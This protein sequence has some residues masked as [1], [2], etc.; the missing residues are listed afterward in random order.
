MLRRDIS[1]VFIGS[2]AGA[3]LVSERAQAQACTPPCYPITAQE[4][5]AG[6]TPT[7]YSHPTADLRRFGGIGNG[8]TD[9]TLALQRAAAVSAAGGGNVI[10]DAGTYRIA[11]TASL[12]SNVTLEFRQGGMLSVD[13]G[14]ELYISGPLVAPTSAKIFP[15][16][17]KVIFGPDWSGV[18]TVY[19]EWWGAVPNGTVNCTD[20]IQN[21]VDSLS[22][23]GI[24]QFAAGQYRTKT[25]VAK[26]NTAFIGVGKDQTLLKSWEAGT[27]IRLEQFA[28]DPAA[29]SGFTIRDLSLDGDFIGT[30]GLSVIGY[31]HF[32]IQDCNI[33]KFK[34]RGVHLHGS[35][36]STIYRTRIF[37]CP[38]GFD[39]ESRMSQDLLVTLNAISLRDCY[40]TECS[41]Y[42]VRVR[43]GSLFAI[44]GG[45]IEGNGTPGDTGT[46]AVLFE[47]MDPQGLGVSAIIDGVWFEKNHGYSAIRI[48][49]PHT[50]YSMFVIRGVQ[51]IAGGRNYGI[52]VDGSG[53][54]PSISIS[55]SVF[56]NASVYD[57][58]VGT[59][60]VGT[61]DHVQCTS[62]SITSPDVVRL[63]HPLTGR[64]QLPGLSI[65]PG[66][67]LQFESLPGHFANDAA[68]ASGGVPVGGVYRNG[69]VLLVRLT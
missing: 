17:G 25:I 21:A 65:M 57:V 33:Y 66:G 14:V 6:Q 18:V 62:A 60:V 69:N 23:G 40:I 68:A 32:S 44:S 11:S 1:K 2:M 19:P 9:C 28:R 48:D 36:S 39:G 38:I 3:A 15:G 58:L 59:R 54:Y 4:V 45:T 20:A 51:V 13:S 16:A 41:T 61:I 63:S 7:D 12:P 34:S 30:T 31:A 53:N 55:H 5:S 43:Q 35:I 47:D 52:F 8:S 10:I 46:G 50:N 29:S 49:A 27:M 22:W 24:L 56:Q 42:A 67:Q 37:K 26:A 64:F